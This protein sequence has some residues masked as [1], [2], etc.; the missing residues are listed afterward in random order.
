MKENVNIMILE[1]KSKSVTYLQDL[2]KDL[3]HYILV[4][5]Y[6]RHRNNFIH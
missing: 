1:V 4:R 3:N 2:G 5:I 6:F